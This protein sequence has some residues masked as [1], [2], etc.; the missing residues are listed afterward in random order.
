MKSFRFSLESVLEYR[1]EIEQEWE[2]KLGAAVGECNR[3]ELGIE[4]L[5]R[6]ELD[7]LDQREFGDSFQVLSWGNYCYRL[8]QNRDRLKERLAGARKKMEEVR[9]GY[10]EASRNRKALDKLKEKRQKEYKK[11]LLKEEIFKPWDGL[12]HN[13]YSD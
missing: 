10:L 11:S 13:R 12:W 2:L 7:A 5:E 4:S 3:L 1:R 6:E 9:K 8:R